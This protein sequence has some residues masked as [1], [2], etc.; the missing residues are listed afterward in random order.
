M[1]KIV[2]HVRYR[3]ELLGKCLD[4]FAARGYGSVTMREIAQDLG[5]STGT[6]YHYFSGK[7]ALFLQLVEQLTKQ[8]ISN[9]LA[10]ADNTQPLGGKIEMLFDFMRKN[11]DYFLKQI[12]IW[13]DYCR[14]QDNTALLSNEIIQQADNDVKQV[15]TNYLQIPAPI[16]ELIFSVMYGI[17]ME[18]L[19]DG[20]TISFVNQSNFLAEMV[21]V[22]LEHKSQQTKENCC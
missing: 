13:V 3:Q 5:V 21:T 18:R 6:L 11:E 19:F 4:I 20:K 14:Q 22:Y 2:D 17:L 7:E 15:I 10:S 1:P 8:D 9:F 16:V 12:L